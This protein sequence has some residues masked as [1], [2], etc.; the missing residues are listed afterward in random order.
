MAT[1]VKELI[2][3]LQNEDQNSPVFYQYVLPEFT[4]YSP[5]EFG[6]RLDAMDDYIYDTLSNEM[7]GI[8]AEVELEEDEESN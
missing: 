6:K 8:L 3:N 2:R 4:D 7:F 1:T 5:E